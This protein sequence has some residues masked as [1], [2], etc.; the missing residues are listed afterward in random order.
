M[1]GIDK[2]MT[3]LYNGYRFE[4]NQRRKGHVSK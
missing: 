3:Y 4:D 1:T 2:H